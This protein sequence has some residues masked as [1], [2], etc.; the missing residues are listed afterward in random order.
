VISKIHR[1]CL[2]TI[3]F[4]GKFQGM[5][6]PQEFIVY[7]IV[8]IEPTALLVQSDSRIGYIDLASGQVDLS[9]PHTGGAYFC[10]LVQ[11]AR[12][13]TLN[14]EE[15]FTL[16][17]NIFATAHGDAGRS[18]NGVVGT[19]NSGAINVFGATE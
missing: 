6:K 13:G 1:N 2:G 14:D 4:D 3:S 7:P 19:D 17:A 15:L 12:V 9:K 10:H 5:R 18:I 16:K 8:D 11:R